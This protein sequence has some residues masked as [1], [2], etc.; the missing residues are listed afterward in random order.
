LVLS[1]SDSR[2]A[3]DKKRREREKRRESGEGAL[4]ELMSHYNKW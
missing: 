4:T 3:A 2:K 1:I